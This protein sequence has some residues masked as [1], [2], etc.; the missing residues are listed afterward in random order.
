MTAATSLRV[1]FKA[2]ASAIAVA[3]SLAAAS[4]AHAGTVFLDVGRIDHGR[5][6]TIQ[7][8]GSTL[9]GPLQ[10]DAFSNSKK[11]SLL[12]WCVDVYHRITLGDYKPDLEYVDTTPHTTDF[13]GHAL[14]AGDTLKVGLLV[15]YGLDLFND[16]P[17]APP[18][19][20][21]VKP[22]RNQF[23]AGSAGNAQYA[24]ALGVYNTAKAA[25]NAQVTAYNARV[26]DR[27]MRLAAVQSAIWQVTSN[28]NVYSN[29]GDAAFDALVDNLSGASLQNYFVGGYGPQGHA[30]HLITP[31]Q[32][33]DSRGRAKPLTQSFA[34][35]DVPEPATWGLMILGFGLAGATLR[36]RRAAI[37]A[38]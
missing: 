32:T 27:Y 18:A 8:I 19:F 25:Y 20:T 30:Y 29:N 11:I 7:G 13:A 2:A 23:P 37:A 24:A 16:V 6:V 15:N 10:F 33:Y 31:V 36:R 28:R 21:M 9:A 4:A 34:V 1:T 3:A 17:T 22:T 5:S 38:A 14:D 26:S 12:A 35:A